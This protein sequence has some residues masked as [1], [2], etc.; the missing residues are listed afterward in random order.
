[1]MRV[2]ML[3]M[4]LLLLAACE[5]RNS[6]EEAPISALK[7]AEAARATM[8]ITSPAFVADGAIPAQFTCDQQSVAPKLEWSGVPS[9]ARSLALI[10]TDPDAP[11]GT[12]THWVVYDLPASA[13][14][15]L[16]GARL[17]DGARVGTNDAK[18]PGWAAP[19]PPAASGVHHYTFTLYAL[20]QKLGD[21][22]KPTRADLER[23]MAGHV[24][25]TGQLTGTYEKMG[26][27]K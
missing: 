19:C 14:T 7:P 23:R 9:S 11:S 21:I 25:A 22:G 27:R 10:V 1:M 12:F 24:I 20:D 16:E 17:P 2:T 4:S 26:A 3:S 6:S 15:I 13:T 8:R 18:K 5:N